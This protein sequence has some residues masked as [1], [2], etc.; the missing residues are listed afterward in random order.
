MDILRR[1]RP[2]PGRPVLRHHPRRVLRRGAHGA[3]D[4]ARRPVRDQPLRGPASRPPAAHWLGTDQFGRDTLSRVILATQ[5]TARITTI[6]LLFSLLIGV[7]IGMV[8]GYRGRPRGCGRHA[9]D[10][11]AADLPDHHDRHHHRGRGRSLA[12]RRRHRAGAIA[13]AEL[14][15]HRAQRR[16]LGRVRNCTSRRPSPPAPAGRTFSCGTCCTTSPARSS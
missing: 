13:T 2:R 14:H 3:V 12:E 16:A 15:P 5:V 8:V 7:P 1:Y 9:V 10:R 11:H 6:S 4:H